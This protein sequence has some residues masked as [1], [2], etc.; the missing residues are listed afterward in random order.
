VGL[1]NKVLLL[2]C[3]LGVQPS[4][5]AEP[6]DK[7]HAVS[8]Q[9]SIDN[10]P[11]FGDFEQMFER[12]MIRVLVPYS[13]TFY[14]HDKGQARGLTADLVRDFERHINKK[15]A[16][17][18]H[19]R[20]VTVVI[21]PTTRERLLDDLVNGLGDIAAGNLTET[22]ERLEQV[23]FFAPDD[24]QV[25]ELILTGP[26]IL[27]IQSID[28]L[29]GATVHVRKSSSYF[30][31]LTALNQRFHEQGKTAIQIV[32]VPDA[33]EDEDLMEMLNAG[34]I[35]IMIADDW[36][37]KIWAQVL[38]KITITGLAIREAGHSGWAMRKQSPEL[39][40][41]VMD[42]YINN[43]QKLHVLQSRLIAFNKQIKQIADNTADKDWQRFER[44]QQLFEKYGDQY[45][46][47]PL[48]LAAQ[49]YQESTLKQEKRGPS[50]AIG[51]MQ[52]LPSTANSLKVGDIKQLE[53]NIHAG[54][55]YLDELMQ[56]YFSDANFQG[57]DRTLFSFASYNAGPGTINRMR[58]EAVNRGLD[59]NR[60]FNQV[61]LVVADKVGWETTT[62]VRNIYKYYVA[63]KLQL[64]VAEHQRQ[65]RASVAM[66][67]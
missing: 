18:L 17:Q 54:T 16:K 34:V 26:S 63:Y 27:P 31:S 41:E 67:N 9:L 40:A 49:G 24:R 19:K 46:F 7:A 57:D 2:A 52:V 39:K 32:T 47:D 66:G 43:I 58:K 13:R 64:E 37:A 56:R 53:P 33:I 14:F 8:R 10:T 22:P 55:K 21:V 1:K 25:S 29:S 44:L 60:W 35:N 38:P 50:G 11:W 20:P 4:V 6:T 23:D 59:P 12:T 15:Y 36:K 51:V 65:A 45:G 3:L 28:E 30:Q 61:E 62:Y 5:F 42:F 48:M